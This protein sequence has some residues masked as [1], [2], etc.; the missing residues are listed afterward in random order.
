MPW[1]CVVSDSTSQVGELGAR[2]VVA[3]TGATRNS[4]I[5]NWDV[6]K[7]RIDGDPEVTAAFDGIRDAAVGMR[8]AL[9]TQDWDATARHL[10]AEWRH[11]VRL[12]PGVTTPAITALLE[13][14]REAGATAG[15]VCGAGGGGC[16]FCLVPPDRKAAVAHALAA[17]GAQI[18]DCAIDEEGVRVQRSA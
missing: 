3:Y 11:R 2:I 9:S 8:H 5:N 16:L 15:K 1:G 12:A 4:G 17:A 13:T 7:R 6:M 18:L 14:A 10:Q